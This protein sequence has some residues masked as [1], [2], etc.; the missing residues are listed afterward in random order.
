MGKLLSDSILDLGNCPNFK[1]CTFTF[2]HFP[3]GALPEVQNRIRKQFSHKVLY[4][5]LTKFFLERF[6][7]YLK[8]S[9]KGFPIVFS[10][11]ARK[12]SRGFF[13]ARKVIFCQMACIY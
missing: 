8:K 9:K 10:N 12:G 5:F 13:Q 4:S 7:Q 11:L 2:M 1:T 6:G 3:V